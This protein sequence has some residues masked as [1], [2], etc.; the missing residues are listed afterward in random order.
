MELAEIAAAMI[1]V[2]ETTPRFAKNLRYFSNARLTLVL[3]VFSLT[4]KAIPPCAPG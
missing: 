2:V 4:P 3:A 1:A